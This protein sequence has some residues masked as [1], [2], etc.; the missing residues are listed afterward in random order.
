MRT[1]DINELREKM[2]RT[3]DELRRL[4]EQRMETAVGIAQ[5]KKEN[6]MPVLDRSR[7]REII[8][9]MTLGQTEEMAGYTRVLCN[10]LFDLSRS[11]QSRRMIHSSKLPEE[12]NAAIAATP[13]IFPS[14]ATV[15][16]QG[17]EGA[18]S[19]SAC[20]K[21]FSQPSISFMGTFRS[22]IQAVDKGLCRYG[23]LPIENSTY[24]SVSEVYD[25]MKKHKFYIVKG[26][27]LQI[28]HCLA[29]RREVPLENIREIYSHE[30]ALG[31]CSAFLESLPNVQAHACENTAVAARQVSAS[32]RDDV[33]AICSPDCAELYGMHIVSDSIQ[34][35][36][37]NFTRFICISREMEIYPGANRV[38]LM[39]NISHKPGSLY[40][41]ISRFASLGLNLVKI[42]SRPIPG[43][44]FEFMFY[45]D[46]EA[47][48]YS[49]QVLNLLAE[50]DSGPEPFVF[51]GAYSEN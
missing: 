13:D 8:D 38:S 16:C 9:R 46:L 17:T 50:M 34:N 45:I 10:T 3:D 47:S 44:D 21:L 33:A 7:E 11:Y 36:D 14:R 41:T 26:I 29:T 49:P 51:L 30:Q 32:G 42:E 28:H 37:H 39:F 20:D 23:I 18:N 25:L 27:K 43:R 35:S 12:I 5:Y 24:G 2:D 15:A 22:V 6:G 4:F 31:Q 40:R 1:M 19:Q 48:V